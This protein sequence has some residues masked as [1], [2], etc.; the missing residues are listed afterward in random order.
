MNDGFVVVSSNHWFLPL[1]LY[2]PS[3]RHNL[4]H[5]ARRITITGVA[6]VSCVR[7]WNAGCFPVCFAPR[8]LSHSLILSLLV[9]LLSGLQFEV[10]L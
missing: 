10:V 7:F 3:A 8:S 5:P 4:N 9:T 6:D 1:R 2:R